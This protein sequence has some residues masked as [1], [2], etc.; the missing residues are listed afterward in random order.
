[1]QDLGKPVNDLLRY[2][3][4]YLAEPT[5]PSYRDRKLPDQYNPSDL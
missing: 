2:D 5:A 1:M 4:N 3:R